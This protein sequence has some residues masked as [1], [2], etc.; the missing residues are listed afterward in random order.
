M[1]NCFCCFDPDRLI[2][3]DARVKDARV[4]CVILIGHSEV[5]KTKL[6]K[7]HFKTHQKYTSYKLLN[8]PKTYLT[9]LKAKKCS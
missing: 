1:G 6:R 3:R 7:S 8:M 4:L 5:R 2:V 9:Y